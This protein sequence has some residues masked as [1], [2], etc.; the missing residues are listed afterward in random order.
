[1][2]LVILR[3]LRDPDVRKAD[4][5]E[6]SERWK[7]RAMEVIGQAYKEGGHVDL[8]YPDKGGQ[9]VIEGDGPVAV[10][11]FRVGGFEWI[12]TVSTAALCFR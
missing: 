7:K 3:P 9:T 12:P 1:M 4:P 8:R 2:D 5:S 11:T 10:E 6:Q